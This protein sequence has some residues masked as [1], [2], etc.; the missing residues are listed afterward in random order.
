MG[1]AVKELLLNSLSNDKN[2]LNI[3]LSDLATGMYIITIKTN[4]FAESKKI[5]IVR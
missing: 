5:S 2:T 1:I 3:N 4:S